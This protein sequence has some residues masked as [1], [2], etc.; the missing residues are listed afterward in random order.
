MLGL[1]YNAPEGIVTVDPST[2]HAWRNVNVGQVLIDG[3]I[4]IVWSAD[5]PIRPVP[6]PHSRSMKEWDSL[7]E[8]LYVRWKNNWINP[9]GLSS[10]PEGGT[11]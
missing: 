1:S 7:I 5:H 3:N 8:D 6:Y 4:R 2:H 9:E 11:L 10:L